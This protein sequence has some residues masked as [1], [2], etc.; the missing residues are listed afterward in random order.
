MVE[1]EDALYVNEGEPSSPVTAAEEPT[2]TPLSQFVS[3][4]SEREDDTPAMELAGT[5]LALLKTINAK[6]SCLTK[7][8]AD[9]TFLRERSENSQP[10]AAFSGP[11]I[12]HDVFMLTNVCL[13]I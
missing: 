4:S 9:I 3:V 1:G 11:V 12:Y 8:E 10:P 7:M 6:M 5:S 13:C 2:E